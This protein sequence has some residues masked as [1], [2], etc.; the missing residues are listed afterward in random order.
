MAVKKPR[1]CEAAVAVLRET[2][3]PAVM[4]GDAGLLHEI[5]ERAGR[6]HNAWKTEKLI[7]DTLSRDHGELIPG[8]T[9]LPGRRGRDGR[10]VRI[11]WLPENAPDYLK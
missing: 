11:F 6:P 9:A 10:R 3:N 2:D 4:W 1:V 5:A 8:W 7:L